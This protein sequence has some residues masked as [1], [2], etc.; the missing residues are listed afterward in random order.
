LLLVGSL[1]IFVLVYTLAGI[2][3]PNIE[4]LARFDT[5]YYTSILSFLWIHY[6][7]DHFLFTDFESLDAAYGHD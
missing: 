5:A 3:R 2:V 4:P 6:Y 7:H 1:I